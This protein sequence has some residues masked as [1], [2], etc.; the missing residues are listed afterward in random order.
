M[1]DTSLVTY[2]KDILARV[3][4]RCE[5]SGERK[6]STYAFARHYYHGCGGHPD[7]AEHAQIA[8]ELTKFLQTTIGWR[9]VS[10]G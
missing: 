4:R 9:P 10:A 2:Q 8:D 5:A 6:V 7:L 3:A 1:G